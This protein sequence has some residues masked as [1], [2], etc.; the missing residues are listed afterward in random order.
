MATRWIDGAPELLSVAEMYQA[1]AAADAGGVPSLELME[2]AGAAVAEAAQTRWPEGEVVVLCGPGN[3]G[4][5]GFVA[6]RLLADAGRQVR[7]VTTIG[8]CLSAKRGQI[9]FDRSIKL[10]QS[11]LNQCHRGG[12]RYWLCQ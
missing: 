4:G 12:G 3:N 5:D 9:L 11:L 7:V 2:A 10:Q 8:S 1:D 6:A